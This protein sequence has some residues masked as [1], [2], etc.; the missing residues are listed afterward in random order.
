MNRHGVYVS[1]VHV[2][3]LCLAGPAVFLFLRA[4]GLYARLAQWQSDAMVRRRSTVQSRDWAQGMRLSSPNR[5]SARN[6]SG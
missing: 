1:A 4:A 6:Q 3:L 2:L 5:E